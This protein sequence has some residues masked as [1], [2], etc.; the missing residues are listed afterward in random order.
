VHVHLAFIVDRSAGVEIA[1]ALG[2]L[3]RRRFPLVEGIGRLDIVVSV[4]QAG[5]LAG[6]VE[7][8]GINERVTGG[9]DDLDVLHTDAGQF[10]GERLGG[11]KDV[12]L[13]LGKRGYG[14]DAEEGLEFV[15]EPGIVAAG[16]VD[17]RRHEGSCGI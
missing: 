11:G 2:R 12:R 9:G 5:G 10:F 13:V 16:V 6:C 14:G 3:E 17:G 15:E 4:A 8:V 1:V 7:P